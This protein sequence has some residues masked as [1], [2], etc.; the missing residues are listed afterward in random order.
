MFAPTR[1]SL[2][3]TAGVQAV[4]SRMMKSGVWQG[5]GPKAG[6][7][8]GGSSLSGYTYCNVREAWA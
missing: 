3:K 5:E 1:R 4:A 6:A 7:G 8:Q 2:I